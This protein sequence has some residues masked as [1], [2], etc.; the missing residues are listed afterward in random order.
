MRDRSDTTIAE[1]RPTAFVTGATGLVGH[2]LMLSLL[3]RGYDLIVLS[4]PDRRRTARERIDRLMMELYPS[5]EAYQPLAQRITVVEGDLR[6]PD[7]GL[8]DA[9]WASTA[10]RVTDIAHCGALLNFTPES[11]DEVMATNLTGA[12]S[13]HRLARA[14]GL[15]TLHHVSTAY[16]VG[17]VQGP[18]AE[19]DCGEAPGRFNNTY[20]RSKYL[21]ERRLRELDAEYGVKTTI[22]RPSCIIGAYE[23]GRTLT[24]RTLYGYI[25]LF[26]QER[27]RIVR[28]E[29]EA[30]LGR[31]RPIY[32]LEIDADRTRNIVPADYVAEAMA[33]IMGRPEHHGGVYHLT[34]P[35]PPSRWESN[36]W[37]VKGLG[38]KDLVLPSVAAL[39]G[40]DLLEVAPGRAKR[41]EQLFSG[42][43]VEQEPS[44]LT[45][46]TEAA[47]AGSG[48]RCPDTDEAYVG[49][50]VRYCVDTRWRVDVE[51]AVDARMPPTPSLAHSP[52][53]EA[54]HA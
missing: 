29:G 37:M 10:E 18:Q 9:D 52:T 34:N 49:R 11:G 16:V 36:R 53:D 20:E 22:Y 39:G 17:A 8:S 6:L 14:A 50:V 2:F 38:F 1:T 23:D 12:E 28:A 24:F 41:F 19:V 3:R 48:V 15:D 44:F 35:T 33:V 13:A 21:S 27:R 7:F 54:A 46:R 25:D 5:W 43:L 42:Y 31:L 32:M 51:K 45:D 26:D 4:R 47:L 30:A 40:D